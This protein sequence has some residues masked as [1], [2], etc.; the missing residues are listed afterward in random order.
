MKEVELFGV[1]AGP[2]IN[3]SKSKV[4]RLNI[5]EE[6]VERINLS[7]DPIKC[8]GIYVG[9]NSHEVEILNWEGRL[10]KNKR[11]SRFMENEKFNIIWQGYC[12]KTFSNC[13]DGIHCH[14]GTGPFKNS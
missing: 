3:W 2:K 1:N 7:D 12:N 13:S 14:S 4:M 9:K 8:L 6:N 11:N 10:E 5:N